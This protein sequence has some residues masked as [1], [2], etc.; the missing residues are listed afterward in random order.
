MLQQLCRL[1]KDQQ[2]LIYFQELLD[3]YEVS[4]N[5]G[6]PIGNLTSQYFANHYLSPADHM[7]KEQAK[8]PAMIRYMDDVLLFANSKE[9]LRDYVREYSAY[10]QDVL[11]LNLH[12]P[13][14]NNV[15]YGVPFLGYVVYADRMRLN[16]RSK[17]RFASKMAEMDT[18]YW[19]E[20]LAE[21]NVACRT[22][23]LFAFV[24]KADS[25]GLRQA[26]YHKG[27]YS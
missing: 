11:R 16:K 2:L 7:I 4:A 17:S 27:Q 23:C 12:P 18:A 25:M 3:S 13:I 24:D 19:M 20:Q 9:E 21:K 6:L 26:L 22:L 10:T 15:C 14:I 8:A 5:M 1:F